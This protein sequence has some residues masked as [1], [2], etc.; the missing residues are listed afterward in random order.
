MQ[1]FD[2]QFFLSF[3]IVALH[4]I[5]FMS[6]RNEDIYELYHRFYCAVSLFFSDVTFNQS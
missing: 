3:H 1:R 5:S 4:F 6:I 2:F